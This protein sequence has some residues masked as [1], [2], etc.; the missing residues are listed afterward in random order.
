MIAGV[1]TICIGA[2]ASKEYRGATRPVAHW[3]A[4]LIPLLIIP[5]T[6]ITMAMHLGAEMGQIEKVTMLLIFEALAIAQ[7]V[8]AIL[9][10]RGLIFKRGEDRLLM[11]TPWLYDNEECIETTQH[12]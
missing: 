3:L 10:F 4:A 2:L 7:L 1:L 12:I 8:L 6:P 11:P 5:L 9:M